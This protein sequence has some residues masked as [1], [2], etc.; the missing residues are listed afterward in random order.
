[1]RETWC[2]AR[3][4]AASVAAVVLTLGGAA[5]CGD[6]ETP[7]PV[8]TSVTATVDDGSGSDATEDTTEDTASSWAEAAEAAVRDVYESRGSAPSAESGDVDDD[9]MLWSDWH[10]DLLTKAV[11][12]LD[13]AGGAP[14]G[15]QELIDGLEEYAELDREAAEIY[16]EHPLVSKR[17]TAI[18]GRLTELR[19]TITAQATVLEVPSCGALLD[20]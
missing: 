8:D 18:E 20:I 6:S 7:P 4:A 11:E 13:A 15:A 2:A 3:L 14:A 10:A 5:A 16:D 1:M 12:A 9:M 17:L 19:E